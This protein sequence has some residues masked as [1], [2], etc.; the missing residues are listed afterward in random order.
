[1]SRATG[2]RAPSSRAPIGARGAN[3]DARAPRRFA[4]GAGR[5]S[6]DELP[7]DKGPR[8]ETEPRTA[9][10]RGPGL[11]AG[12]VSA[13]AP[14]GQDHDRRTAED[15]EVQAER[16]VRDVIQIEPN[17]PRAIQITPPSHLPEA[18]QPRQ[19]RHPAP[20]TRRVHLPQQRAVA[21]LER[22]GA[23]QAHLTPQDV[24]QLRQ[25]VQA[26]PPQELSQPRHPGV[27]AHLEQHPAGRLVVR[28]ELLE[29]ILGIL[30]HRPELQ[31]AEDPAV[32]ALAPLPEEHGTG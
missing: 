8:F 2:T 22:A 5:Y 13:G 20:V 31:Q 3:P 27:L 29:P 17:H 25:L 10:G 15:P 6:W 30:A 11:G 26:R 32:E 21:E 23:H 16:P 14:P 18:R 9:P 19:D 24:P 12:A 4:R 7:L 28:L 1:M